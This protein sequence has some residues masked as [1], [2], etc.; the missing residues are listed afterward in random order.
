MLEIHPAD[1]VLYDLRACVGVASLL[2]LETCWM[3]GQKLPQQLP[4]VIRQDQRFDAIDTRRD[5]VYV[6][7]QASHASGDN[8][9][10]TLDTSGLVFEVDQ[11]SLCDAGF[12]SLNLV[13]P[14]NCI[15]LGRI[16]LEDSPNGMSCAA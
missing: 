7:L 1:D 3:F 14:C 2:V 16:K 15:F 13:L 5:V 8:V 9:N 12:G 4:L 6:E 10:S 11:R